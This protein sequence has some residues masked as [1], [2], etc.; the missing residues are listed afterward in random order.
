[1]TLISGLFL[2]ATFAAPSQ[3]LSTLPFMAA[4]ANGGDAPF[5]G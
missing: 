5:D 4:V 1:L 2:P 3:S